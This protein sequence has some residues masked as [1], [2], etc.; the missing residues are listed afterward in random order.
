MKR[1][2]DQIEQ[3]QTEC[4]IVIKTKFEIFLAFPP[5]FQ[6]TQSRRDLHS[7]YVRRQKDNKP[8]EMNQQVSRKEEKEEEA[9]Q[10]KKL[11]TCYDS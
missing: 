5:N 2:S 10:T 3:I 9:K 6:N 8:K 1:Q 7:T 4:K 11:L